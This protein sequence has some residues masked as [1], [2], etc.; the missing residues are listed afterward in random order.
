[1][2][3]LNCSQYLHRARF[4]PNLSLFG[5]NVR[6]PHKL[7]DISVHKLLAIDSDLPLYIVLLLLPDLKYEFLSSKAL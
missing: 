1:M 4:K 6:A 3:T 2:C 5:K 7:S